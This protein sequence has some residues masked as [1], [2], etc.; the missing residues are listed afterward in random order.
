MS[1]IFTRLNAGPPQ[2]SAREAAY[3]GWRKEFATFSNPTKAAFTIG[4]TRCL[5]QGGQTPRSFEE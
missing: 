1:T 3:A 2:V 5:D 4:I